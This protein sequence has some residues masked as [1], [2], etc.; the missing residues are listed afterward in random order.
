MR[1]LARRASRAQCFHQHLSRQRPPLLRRHPTLVRT[2]HVRTLHSAGSLS[3]GHTRSVK[4][5]A[6]VPMESL[7]QSRCVGA[8]LWN[9]CAGWCIAQCIYNAC[10]GLQLLAAPMSGRC[11]ASAPGSALCIPRRTHRQ[12]MCFPVMASR[13]CVH[14]A[15]ADALGAAVEGQR[16]DEIKAKHPRGITSYL[17]TPRG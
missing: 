9:A 5:S 6:G 17:E 16:A 10:K 1:T 11:V 3:Q 2:Q 12:L 13:T 14:P 8:L 4:A 7:H 15:P